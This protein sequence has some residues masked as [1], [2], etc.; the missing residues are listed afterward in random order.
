MARSDA[1]RCP[2]LR[3]QL[4]GRPLALRRHASSGLRDVLRGKEYPG[5]DIRRASPFFAHN[6]AAGGNIGQH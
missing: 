6:P 1:I 2:G 3:L 4:K 5:H